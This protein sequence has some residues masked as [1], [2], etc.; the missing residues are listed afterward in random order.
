MAVVKLMTS[1]T[2][3]LVSILDSSSSAFSHLFPLGA[4]GR[5]TGQ[6]ASKYGKNYLT[7]TTAI[8]TSHTNVKVRPQKRGHGSKRVKHENERTT[9]RKGSETTS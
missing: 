2:R 4:R 5:D 9:P 6:S 8:Y 3:R 7:A 1:G